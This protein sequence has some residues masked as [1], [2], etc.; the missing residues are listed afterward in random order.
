MST[1]VELTE[2]ELAELKALTKES[3]DSTAIRFAMTEYLR[4]ARRMQL[5]AMSGE[6]TMDE[7]WQALEESEVR[8][9]NGGS[10]TGAR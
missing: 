1:V 3:D 2:D 5:K 9:Q 10:T 8:D 7:N 4:H 6:V